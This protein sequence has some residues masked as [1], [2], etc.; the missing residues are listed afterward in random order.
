MM[1]GFYELISMMDE[2]KAGCV[3]ATL[4][5]VEGSS[6]L[7]E[8]AMMLFWEEN[9]AGMISAGCVEADLMERARRVAADRIPQYVMYNMKEEDDLSW[10]QGAGCNGVLHV[11]LE[12]VDDK[13]RRQLLYAKSMLEKGKS[14]LHRKEI[15]LMPYPSTVNEFIKVEDTDQASLFSSG[16]HFMDHEGM[17][18]THLYEPK[19]R[20]IVF[21][22][23]FDGRTVAELA[24]KTGWTIMMVDWRPAFLCKEDY[25]FPVE[26]FCLES[27]GLSDLC[28]INE[29]DFIVVM[30]HN[31][32]KDKDFLSC[33]LKE[34]LFYVGVLG[35]KERTERLLGTKELP[36]FIHS[37]VGLSIGS[38]GPQEIAV[39]ILAEMI[40]VSRQ[41][42]CR[43]I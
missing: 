18:Y 16:I 9:Q 24:Y 2:L 14:I 23:G 37:P 25:S 4:I 11:W 21:G 20:L 12:V 30:S 42:T 27:D 19:P 7:K 29:R 32:Q 38:R 35:P 40:K 3:A 10:G 33:L 39:S 26:T 1:I 13:L 34:P 17:V 22:A 8:G 6:Y 5:K 43:Q 36:D 15:S 31:F 28:M 41:V